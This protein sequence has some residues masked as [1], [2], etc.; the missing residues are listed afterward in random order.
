[1]LPTRQSI[2]EYKIK[3]IGI[4]VTVRFQNITQADEVKVW[5]YSGLGIVNSDEHMFDHN[6]CVL[7]EIVLD[8]KLHKQT[9]IP[10]IEDAT[11]TL[12]KIQ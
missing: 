11:P 4:Q 1:M 7:G 2:Q 3:Y 5:L 12:H 8:I 10:V 9:I 6:Q